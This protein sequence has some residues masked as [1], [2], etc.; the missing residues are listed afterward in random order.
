MKLTRHQT[1]NPL[2]TV[3]HFSIHFQLFCSYTFILK[4]KRPLKAVS[5][6]TQ[7]IR[8]KKQ[9]IP[10]DSRIEAM[11]APSR[12]ENMAIINSFSQNYC[13]QN[14]V[15]DVKKVICLFLM[16]V[17]VTCG[18]VLAPDLERG[19]YIFNER[20]LWVHNTSDTSAEHIHEYDGQYLILHTKSGSLK[21]IDVKSTEMFNVE[22]GED[23]DSIVDV[24]SF[25]W[26]DGLMI[27]A[28]DDAFY[29][30]FIRR[31]PHTAELFPFRQHFASHRTPMQYV[32]TR[33]Q[34]GIVT[35][36]NKWVEQRKR[37][38]WRTNEGDSGFW[39]ISNNYIEHAVCGPEIIVAWNLA[40]A[41]DSI[42][43]QFWWT[44]DGR[45]GR[46]YQRTGCFNEAGKTPIDVH[47]GPRNFIVVNE[48]HQLYFAGQ[49]VAGQRLAD[50]SADST[51]VRISTVTPVYYAR[52]DCYENI[53]YLN[54]D[55]KLY[56][57][58][59]TG[60]DPTQWQ[61]YEIDQEKLG[62]RNCTIK[63]LKSVA[64]QLCI[65]ASVNCS[66]RNIF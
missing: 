65:V 19:G 34:M 29:R 51:A 8:T 41:N 54:Q 13:D 49:R 61:D 63:G 18:V 10:M 56:G 16:D 6:V 52:V 39:G 22:L 4:M 1:K 60:N 44:L 32:E 38:S 2:Q 17:E 62:L 46:S 33:D 59:R 15:D 55:C 14:V 53:F 9:Q 25:A 21:M 48:Q 26:N 3:V 11:I 45:Y 27:K 42:P 43:P 58:R 5:A 64:G 30:G 50:Q 28:G 40:S 12:D 35:Q 7:F 66:M 47:C 23:I 24:H 37:D 20:A 57:I 36:T 31:R